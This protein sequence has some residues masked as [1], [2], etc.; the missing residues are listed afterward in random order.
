MQPPRVLRGGSPVH[1]PR[2]PVH[3]PR[4]P[5]HSACTPCAHASQVAQLQAEREALGRGLSLA[6]RLCDEHTRMH[7]AQHGTGSVCAAAVLQIID[8]APTPRG[9]A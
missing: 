1:P 8:G 5:V 6:E 9:D 4:G 3:P 2:S 7:L